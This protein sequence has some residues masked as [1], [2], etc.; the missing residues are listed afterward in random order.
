MFHYR[1]ISYHAARLHIRK[2]CCKLKHKA[3]FTFLGKLSDVSLEVEQSNETDSGFYQIKCSARSGCTPA[4]ISLLGIFTGEKTEPIFGVNFTCLI[5]YN[6][7]DGWT[8]SCTGTVPDNVYSSLN[9]IACRPTTG[10]KKVDDEKEIKYT[11]CRGIIQCTYMG[12]HSQAL[13]PFF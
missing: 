1:L 12:V 2:S 13:S 11:I 5:N 3:S 10:N 4:P 7:D 6:D 8:V 9:S